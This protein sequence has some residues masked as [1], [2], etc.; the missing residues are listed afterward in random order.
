MIR[1]LK[2]SRVLHELWPGQMHLAYAGQG[3]GS[4]AL[5]RPV[6]VSMTAQLPRRPDPSALSEAIPL[7]YIGCNKNGFW[8]VREAAGGSGGLFLFKQSAARFARRQSE[9]GGCAMMFLAEPFDLDVENQGGRVAGVL[10]AA[11]KFVVRFIGPVIAEWRKLIAEISDTFSSQ[12]RHRDA[13]EKELFRG[14]YTLSSKNDDD[15][16]I[17]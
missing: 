17:P 14:Q 5:R 15:L 11:C 13:I 10:A 12:R 4:A 9:P 16:P 8:V 1:Q 3:Q 2:H 7:F 6:A